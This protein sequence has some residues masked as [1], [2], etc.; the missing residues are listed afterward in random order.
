MSTDQDWSV[1]QRAVT[2]IAKAP[3]DVARRHTESANETNARTQQAQAHLN[4]IAEDHRGL[5][6]RL[7][8]LDRE[9][10]S[11]LTR[12]RVSPAGPITS[13]AESPVTSFAAASS[14]ADELS[15]EIANVSQRLDELDHAKG[16][17][18]RRVGIFA[19]YAAPVALTAAAIALLHGRWQLL[20]AAVVLVFGAM[21]V[22]ARKTPN[23][24]TI[25]PPVIAGVVVALLTVGVTAYSNFTG[26]VVGYALIALALIWIASPR[27][28][29]KR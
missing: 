26:A 20:I 23:R 18:L 1:Y 13:L 16:E 15:E 24:K 28:R 6:D 14:Q 8:A 19:T 21:V 7:D 10:G 9:L 22:A 27:R 25:W 5:S 2:A 4:R 17:L 11:A 29:K 12:H 3:S